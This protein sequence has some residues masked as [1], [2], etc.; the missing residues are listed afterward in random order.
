MLELRTVPQRRRKNTCLC[1]FATSTL[2][3]SLIFTFFFFFQHNDKQKFI[4][5]VI[6]FALK[7][8]VLTPIFFCCFDFENLSFF[9]LLDFKLQ[10]QKS[11]VRTQLKSSQDFCLL[12]KSIL[13]VSKM[14][15]LNFIKG[16][17][18]KSRRHSYKHSFQN[19]SLFQISE[20]RFF[21]HSTKY[22]LAYFRDFYVKLSFFQILSLT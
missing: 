13:K 9:I 22:I 4:T 7:I 2:K 21:V 20:V 18:S 19:S 10:R 8:L 5:Y 14:I 1:N 17:I 11:A 16:F 3:K 15:N 12:P 6:Q